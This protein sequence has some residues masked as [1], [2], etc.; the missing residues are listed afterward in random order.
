MFTLS[1]ASFVVFN[2]HSSTINKLYQDP[3]CAAPGIG[4]QMLLEK[5]ISACARARATFVFARAR[6]CTFLP[7]INFQKGLFIGC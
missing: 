4:K 7:S 5:Y 1:S 3:I 6:A 2:L